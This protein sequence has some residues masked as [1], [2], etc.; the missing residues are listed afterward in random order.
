MGGEWLELKRVAHEVDRQLK[1]GQ[2]DGTI[3]PQFRTLVHGD[4]K[5]A[6]IL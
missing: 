1:G 5:A 4:M 6:N 2:P 3:S